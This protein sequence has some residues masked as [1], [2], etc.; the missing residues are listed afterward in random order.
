[1]LIENNEKIQRENMEMKDRMNNQDKRIY[2]LEQ[3]IKDKDVS[4]NSNNYNSYIN[5]NINN[6]ETIE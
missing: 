2:E 3:T 5:H 1:M 4:D 6:Y